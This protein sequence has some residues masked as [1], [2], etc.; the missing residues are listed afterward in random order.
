MYGSIKE[1]TELAKKE[2]VPIWKI[3]L[4]TEMK[5]TE[6]SEEQVYDKL[7][8]RYEVMYK[9]VHK[10]L[11][12]P[13][14]ITGNL[15]S[16]SAKKQ[17]EYSEQQDTLGGFLIN[18]IMA[19]A[20]SASEVNAS[21]G[22]I[23]AAP[24]A[25]SCGI[26][27]AVIIGVSEHYGLS[28]KDTLNGLLTASGIGTVVINNATV[29]GAEG[30]CQ[31]EC[32]VAAAMAAAAV[33]QMR[34]GTPDMIGDVISLTLM[35]CMGL[36]CDP[37]AGLVQ[38][39]CAQR[40]ASQAVNAITSADMI[41]GGMTIPIPA[42]EVGA[43]LMVDMAHIAG[44]VAAGLHPSPIPYA[45][46]VTTTTHKTL[47]GPRGGMILANKEAAEKFNFNKAIFPGIQGGPLMHVI[48]G[49]AICLGEA[50]KPE[51]KAYQEQVVKN[52]K[53]LSAALIDEGFDILT[54]GTDNHLMLVD[55]RNMDISGKELQNRCD[56]AY[57]TLNKNT[58]PNDPRSPFVTSGV[59]IGTPAVTT[60]GMVE[61]DMKEIAH[62]IHMVATDYDAKA[63]EVREQVR[64]ICGAHPI[65]Q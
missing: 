55:L 41:L 12:E 40:N 63:D 35:N 22:K 47:R 6:C 31:A 29:S 18:H 45:D 64:A 5:I 60:R 62:L 58:V 48:A 30:G 61:S 15:I 46:V 65:Y 10:A 34:G 50:L 54:G 27:P 9:S 28:R 24:T 44:L 4:D 32:G 17:Y 56:E 51:F 59:R 43:V 49:K 26:L 57:I 7:D 19:L 53:A 37:V 16:G 1:L 52:A 33:V 11:Q 42:D 8:K 25:G 13:Q 14:I 21:M 20:L 23:C 2:S 3:I 38:V 39:P 36:I